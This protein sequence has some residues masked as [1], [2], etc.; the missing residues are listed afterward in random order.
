MGEPATNWQCS[1]GYLFISS[2]FMLSLA[3]VSLPMVSLCVAFLCMASLFS[4][5]EPLASSA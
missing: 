4:Y 3:I 1:A 5:I 2:F